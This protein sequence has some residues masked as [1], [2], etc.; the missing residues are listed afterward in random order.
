[1]PS[2]R[3][4]RLYNRA[5][6]ALSFSNELYKLRRELN[7]QIDFREGAADDGD[8]RPLGAARWFK[9]RRISIAEAYLEV[10]RDLDSEHSG[11]RLRA[12]R[13][14][15]DASF[16][17]QALDMPLNTARVQLFLMKAAVK[18]RD[19]RRRQLELLADF[20]ESSYGQSAVTRKLLDR[21]G[22]IELPESGQKLRDLGAGFDGHV[23]DAASTGRKNPT[24]LIIDAFIKGMSEIT[25]S[26][27]SP[28]SM[29]L[30]EEAVEAGHIA[31]IRVDI[32][33][34]FG[35]MW[36]GGRFHF[37]ALLPHMER[38]S[39]VKRF[40][41]KNGAVLAPLFA[42]MEED[43]EGRVAAIRR[44]MHSFNAGPRHELNKGFPDKKIYRVKKLKIRNL[45]T[46]VPIS[47]A[48]RSHLAELL[49]KNYR[50]V[51]FNRV[52][53]MKVKRSEALSAFRRSAI[54][55]GEL[56]YI[57]TRYEL[58]R[59]EYRDMSPDSLKRRYFP[60][61]AE[62]EHDS[63]FK[64]P[65]ALHSAL[66]A[67]GLKVKFI[68]PLEH[69]E[70]KAAAFLE[71]CSGFIDQVEIY[72][73]VEAAELGAGAF[74][75]FAAAVAQVNAER[76][77]A[78][79][80]PLVAVPGSDAT[81]RSREL[82]GMG[83]LRTGF[84]KGRR[85]RRYEE[86]H[87]ALPAG[88]AAL[89]LCA[90]TA[91]AGPGGKGAATACAAGADGAG[92]GSGRSAAGGLLCMGKVA[93]PVCNRIGDEEDGGEK[94]LPLSRLIRYLN[95]GLSNALL[96]VAGFAIALPFIGAG[97]SC[98]WLGI[99]G[100]RN[101]LVD[102]FA[103]R[104]ARV[105]RWRA[106]SISWRNIAQ[107]LFWTG[108][109]VPV[110]AGVKFGFDA[111][112]PLAHAGFLY[113]FIRFF[114]ISLAN[115]LYLVGHNSL[116][117]FDRDV[118]RANFFRNIISWPFATVTA[119][120]ASGI[121]IPVIVQSK[122]WS[123]VIAGFIEGG[124]KYIKTLR[125]RRRDVEELV[126][127]ILASRKKAELAV[128]VFDLLYLY[129]EEPRL[130]SSLRLILKPWPGD[131][132]L[133]ESRGQGRH[134]VLTPQALNRLTRIIENRDISTLLVDYALKNVPREISIDLISLVTDTLPEFRKW[135][136]SIY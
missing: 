125:L 126:P 80:A 77:Q 121:G 87:I 123:D 52:L 115:G 59:R 14:M 83:F 68:K 86:R 130:R 3:L 6:D 58:L 119:A 37:M 132:L 117:G 36:Q 79:L 60:D 116:R 1:M 28:D 74:A 106:R 105:R 2:S 57:E 56:K 108:L 93:E 129:R 26:Y 61:P 84:M 95:P 25:V 42:G 63:A 91:A 65:E 107:S 118:I 54:G 17:N 102:L 38:G 18:S 47:G 81:G 113:E 8:R 124:G 100:C 122:I 31:G 112:W 135:M 76:A 19:D 9:K 78:G 110:L 49:W 92:D 32:G 98:L 89:A 85:G 48:K 88:A 94:A 90:G 21:L 75:D 33:L 134:S 40:F 66:G 104:G 15:L 41:D 73:V 34:E 96:T 50:H 22:L 13:V 114:C 45:K 11:R 29:E 46:I 120:F 35:A 131:M 111:L 24:Q 64:D 55:D 67:A 109:S 97:Y 62:A 5:V 43:E 99:T 4:V 128:S 69:G 7:A 30:M 127:R 136:K 16:H 71:A 103:Y 101:A 51:M 72:N 10:V 70:E 20:S 12:L 39:D 133:S 53:L 23:H 82:P 44:L 27:Y